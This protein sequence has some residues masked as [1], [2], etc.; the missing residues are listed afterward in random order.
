MNRGHFLV[1][2]PRN[3]YKCTCTVVHNFLKVKFKL[4]WW[5]RDKLFLTDLLSLLFLFSCIHIIWVLLV[6]LT[7][8]IGVPWSL[9]GAFSKYL[10][11][12]CS[13]FSDE[14]NHPCCWVPCWWTWP[15]SKTKHSWFFPNFDPIFLKHLMPTLFC[16]IG[17]VSTFFLRQQLHF[18]P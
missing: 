15:M 7:F 14:P 3:N 18:L 13:F 11:W 17:L 16:C 6:L 2:L 12:W 10:F 8:F 4:H 1:I 5:C 9:E